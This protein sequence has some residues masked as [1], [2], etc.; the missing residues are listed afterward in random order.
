MSPEVLATMNWDEFKDT[1]SRMKSQ[2]LC[3]SREPVAPPQ[4]LQPA[5]SSRNTIPDPS[6]TYMAPQF[7]ETIEQVARARMD[8]INQ[9]S[10][11]T[12]G[13]V[14]SSQ[15]M[16]CSSS[17]SERTSQA[18]VPTDPI[19]GMTTLKLRVVD[20]SKKKCSSQLLFASGL[21]APPS[22]PKWHELE[23]WRQQPNNSFCESSSDLR[24]QFGEGS[25]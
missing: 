18:I 23:S 5:A 3:V 7:Q 24:R 19:R 1:Q 2:E 11:R 8:E 4:A 6:D 21:G 13:R 20:T 17:N 14:V 22:L 12:L 15:R 9:T 10:G 16:D 25:D